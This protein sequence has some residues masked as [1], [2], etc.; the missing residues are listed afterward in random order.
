MVSPRLWTTKRQWTLGRC[1]G[2]SLCDHNLLMA[3][4]EDIDS[5]ED[6]HPSHDIVRG[7]GR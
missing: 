5:T 1:D 7:I 4:E 3:P 6:G 2:P